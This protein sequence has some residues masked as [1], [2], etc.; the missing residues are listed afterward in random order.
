MTLNTITLGKMKNC[1]IV[2]VFLSS[3]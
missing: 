1:P 2:G 3:A